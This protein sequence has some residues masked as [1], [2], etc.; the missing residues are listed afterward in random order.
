MT[1]NKYIRSINE[2]MTLREFINAYYDGNQARF[3]KDAK[4]DA[5]HVNRQLRSES[6]YVV[7]GTVVQI[8]Y[9][10]N[11]VNRENRRI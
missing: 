6:Y 5:Q 7:N 8:K 9:E 3:S 1:A 10:S 4:K 2:V 11:C